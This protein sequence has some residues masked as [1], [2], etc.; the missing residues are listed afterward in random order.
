MAIVYL[1]RDLKHDRD[2]AVKVLRPEVMA[3][4]G[5]ERF[6]REIRIAARLSHPNILPLFDSAEVDGQIFYVMPFVAGET[7]RDRLAREGPLPVA[8]AIEIARQVAIGLDYAHREG[9]VHRDIKPENI[10]IQ[11]GQAVV[12]DFGIARAIDAAA[13][14]QGARFTETGVAL[15]TPRYMSPEQIAGDRVDGATDIYSLGCVLFEMV[16]GGPPFDGP[17]AASVLGRHSIE[18]P[19]SPRD[20][21]PDLPRAIEAVVMT[22][23]AKAPNDRFATAGQM[24][25]ALAGDRSLTRRRLAGR[26][27]TGRLAGTVAALVAASLGAWWIASTRPRSAPPPSRGGVAVLYLDVRDSADQYLADGITEEMIWRLGRIERLAIPSRAAV[28]RYRN[29]ASV[30]PGILGQ[31]LGAQYLVSG[32]VERG[33]ARLRVRVEL[34]DATTGGHVWGA[35]FDRDFGDVLAIQDSIA[36]AVA[37]EV[38]GRLAAAE[39]VA[40]MTRPTDNP[41]AYDHYLRG[42]FHLSRRTSEADGRRAVQEYEAALALAPRF[43]AALARL[44]LVYGIYASWPWAH[45]T[46]GTDSLIAR[47]LAAADRAIALDSASS[48]GWLA[49]G[50]LLIPGPVDEDAGRAFGVAPNLL[51][52]GVRCWSVER[53]CRTE[54]IRALER[55]VQLAPRD[56]EAW[57]QLGRVRMFTS[58]DDAAIQR[59][60][61]LEPD[62]AVSAWL[63]GLNHLGARRF[64]R[65]EGMLDSALVLGRRDLSVYGLRAEAR[66]ARGNLAGATADLATVRG[67]VGDDPIA[68]AFEA[69]MRIAIDA[70]TGDSG[71]A[72]VRL[73]SLLTR[74]PPARHPKRSILLALAAAS[75]TSGRLEE[76]LEL[77]ARVHR[78]PV[79]PLVLRSTLWDPVA[80]DPRFRAIA[81]GRDAESR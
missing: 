49:R 17:T 67:L 76:G 4:L 30:E 18:P 8:E 6:L 16:T 15:G 41:E 63:L 5:S 31:A 64:D 72:R 2:V 45:P 70:R 32:S 10:L 66:L 55:A 19:P 51:V 13:E 80:A 12:S 77:L 43:P 62:R 22:A 21:R 48:D 20:R 1:A 73:D 61:D 59:S 11:A 58:P 29:A 53:R 27:A 52:S 71:S 37:T 74:H 46:L 47:G 14:R 78:D 56:A 81:G 68:A 60:L 33:L 75:V 39:R 50:F 36:G 42:N 40:L 35:T 28:R 44:G 57:Y 34:V 25:E 9:I 7:L 3:A 23:L 38:V 26:G 79:L 65:A 69:A 54:A 24:A